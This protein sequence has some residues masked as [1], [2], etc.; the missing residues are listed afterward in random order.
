VFGFVGR[1][2]G[3]GVRHARFAVDGEVCGKC[4]WAEGPMR[5]GGAAKALDW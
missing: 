4:S 3:F 5:G 2:L 1:A